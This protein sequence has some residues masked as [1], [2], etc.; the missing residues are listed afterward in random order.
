[1][2][3]VEYNPD[4]DSYYVIFVKAASGYTRLESNVERLR[5]EFMGSIE[6]A[7]SILDS[8]FDAIRDRLD[9]S[10]GSPNADE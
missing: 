2:L 10:P 6:A 9:V 4:P 5:K 3:E 7:R 8:A 1:M